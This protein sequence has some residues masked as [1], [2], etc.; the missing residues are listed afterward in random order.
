MHPTLSKWLSTLELYNGGFRFSLLE[1]AGIQGY[2]HRLDIGGVN[3]PVRRTSIPIVS[4][5]RILLLGIAV[6]CL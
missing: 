2:N 4:L 5:W 3:A 1:G 6:G